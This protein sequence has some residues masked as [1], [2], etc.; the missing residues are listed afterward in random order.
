[1]DWKQQEN[2][3][4]VFSVGQRNENGNFSQS[5]SKLSVPPLLIILLIFPWIQ[6][7]VD[8]E[9]NYFYY[10]IVYFIKDRQDYNNK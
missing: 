9:H 3:E 1:M 4:N 10:E 5:D 8:N 7:Y 2:S 6:P